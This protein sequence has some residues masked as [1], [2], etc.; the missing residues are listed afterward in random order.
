MSMRRRKRID[1]DAEIRKSEQIRRRGLVMSFLS[2]AV[3]ASVIIGAGRMAG[4][5][6]SLP[7][8]AFPV[9]CILMA[10]LVL[11]ATL[12]RRARLKR[13]REERAAEAA[14]RPEDGQ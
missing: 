8:M 2:F 6:T 12:R 9:A 10:C 1:W 13:E 14:G 3:A 7:R 11:G 5:E 4:A